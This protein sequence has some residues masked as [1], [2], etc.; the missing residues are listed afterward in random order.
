MA[1]EHRINP[2]WSEETPQNKIKYCDGHGT[3]YKPRLKRRGPQ[4]E[5]K[6]SQGS[7]PPKFFHS[8]RL[9]NDAWNMVVS[10]D[11]FKEG[12]FSG[13]ELLNFR[14]V[15]RLIST[16]LE[17]SKMALY[18]PPW[19]RQWGH[20]TFVI[21]LWFDL[22]FYPWCP[23]H[24]NYNSLCR[25]CLGRWA[26]DNKLQNGDAKCGSIHCLGEIHHR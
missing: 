13:G 20:D 14:S 11:P 3:P 19:S 10:D 8:S 6:I 7:T 25:Y 22:P 18:L 16:F 1:M 12:P 24:N 15:G 17:L 9:K 26:A 2:D 4:N 23:G 21:A 5:I